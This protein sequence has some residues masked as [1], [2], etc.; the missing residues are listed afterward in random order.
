MLGHIGDSN[1]QTFQTIVKRANWFLVRNSNLRP[2]EV[3]TVRGRLLVLYLVFVV[4]LVPGF[5]AGSE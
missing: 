3:T 5:L 1:V 2:H 4:D